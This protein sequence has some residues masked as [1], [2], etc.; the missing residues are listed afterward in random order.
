MN[1]WPRLGNGLDFRI[2][3]D[4]RFNST[5]CRLDW[6]RQGSICIFRA[7]SVC[8]L[9]VGT[10]CF[11]RLIPSS[12][13][14]WKPSEPPSLERNI[15]R[16]VP[17]PVPALVLNRGSSGV[18]GVNSANICFIGSVIKMGRD[19]QFLLSCT[20]INLS[21]SGRGKSP[22]IIINDYLV[23]GMIPRVSEAYYVVSWN[24]ICL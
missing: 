3:Q 12:L 10:Q 5:T 19:S 13:H 23:T 15:P 20:E 1:L 21:H 4:R 18:S 6:V 7:Q 22:K 16:R 17:V 11:C 14:R 24:K 8:A 2:K 9:I